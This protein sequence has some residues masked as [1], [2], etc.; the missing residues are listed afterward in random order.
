MAAIYF[1]RKWTLL[2]CVYEHNRMMRLLN[3]GD[4]ATL[5]NSVCMTWMGETCSDTRAVLIKSGVTSWI[6]RR[7][8]VSVI[9]SVMEAFKRVHCV[10]N[11][12]VI[13]FFNLGGNHTK[14]HGTIG[15]IQCVTGV[16]ELMPQRKLWGLKG[17]FNCLD[18]SACGTYIA[19]QKKHLYSFHFV[20]N[21][22]SQLALSTY[23]YCNEKW[24]RNSTACTS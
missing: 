5:S 23:D 9:S 11:P 7:M 20:N 22:I 15:K 19:S 24:E 6:E 4:H 12:F 2:N 1:C 13:Q 18:N 8:S 17:P 16:T 10:T 21:L 3:V 14:M